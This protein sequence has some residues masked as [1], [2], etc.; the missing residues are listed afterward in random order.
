MIVTDRDITSRNRGLHIIKTRDCS[1][2]ICICQ[3]R[4]RILRF[5]R[6]NTTKLVSN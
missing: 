2:P 3:Q 5:P 4:N 6:P 1:R